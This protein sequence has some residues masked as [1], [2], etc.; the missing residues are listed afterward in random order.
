MM[1]PVPYSACLIFEA[2]HPPATH[3]PD[4]PPVFGTWQRFYAVVV[5]FLA[6]QIVLYWLLTLSM[7]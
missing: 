7:S 3:D 4:K 6:V 2:M 5:A 1:S